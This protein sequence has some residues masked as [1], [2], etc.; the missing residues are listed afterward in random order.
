[1]ISGPDG[2]TR[3]HRRVDF[4]GLRAP[5]LV[6]RKGC[7]VLSVRFDMTP[8]YESRSSDLFVMVTKSDPNT[9]TCSHCSKQAEFVTPVGRLC[10]G[11]AL[12]ETIYQTPTVDQW[13][14]VLL[15]TKSRTVGRS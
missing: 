12:K 3:R 6:V 15:P 2:L 4:T 7:L 5:A 11:H 14:P 8:K 1:M 9:K 13:M 10:G